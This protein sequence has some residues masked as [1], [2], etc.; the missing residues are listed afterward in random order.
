MFV[1]FNQIKS[2][3]MDIKILFRFNDIDEVFDE[4]PQELYTYHQAVEYVRDWNIDFDTNY[5][6]IEDF[7]TNEEYY[8]IEPVLVGDFSSIN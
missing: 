2:R 6:S 3:F 4:E 1:P 8:E 5:Q 7:N